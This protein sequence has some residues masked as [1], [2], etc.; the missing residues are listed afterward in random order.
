VHRRLVELEFGAPL[1]A[2]LRGLRQE[3]LSTAGV[4]GRLRLSYR[5]VSRWLVDFGLDDATLI[6]KAL[7]EQEFHAASGALSSGAR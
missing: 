6:R 7:A 5:T 4:A 3:G 1:P 2:V